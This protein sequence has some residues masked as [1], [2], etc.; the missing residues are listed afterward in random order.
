MVMQA[1]VRKEPVS[2]LLNS[3]AAVHMTDI[4]KVIDMKASFVGQPLN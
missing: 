2:L 4:A 3:W 1:D